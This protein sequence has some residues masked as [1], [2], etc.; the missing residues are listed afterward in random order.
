MNYDLR[1]DLAT[2]YFEERMGKVY[3]LNKHS[4]EVTGFYGR[5][6]NPRG[7]DCYF[8]TVLALLGL[9]KYDKRRCGT[10]D[11]MPDSNRQVVKD[12]KHSWV[13]YSF[14]G[15]AFV[16]DPLIGCAIPREMYY[17]RCKPRQVAST[18]TQVEVLKPYLTSR[19]T[20]RLGSTDWQFKTLKKDVIDETIENSVYYIFSALQRGRLMGH[21]DD[22]DCEVISFIACDPRVLN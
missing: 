12:Y 10:I 5:H 8:L 13:E 18:R 17:D 4:G 20:Y 14:D 2:E 19:Y 16:Y 9:E 22:D 15:E 21:F 6:L 7:R 11:T 3:L 1:N